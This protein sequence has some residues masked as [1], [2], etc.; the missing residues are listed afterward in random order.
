MR[1]V[2]AHHRP[3]GP[4][5]DHYPWLAGP[6]GLG[7]GRRHDPLAGT[8]WLPTS[9]PTGRSTWSSLHLQAEIARRPRRRGDSLAAGHRRRSASAGSRMTSSP[10]PILSTRCRSP[11]GAARRFRNIRG[12]RQILNRHPDLGVD[13]VHRDFLSE[14]A[15]A[16]RLRP[17]RPRPV[18]RHPALRPQMADGAATRAAMASTK[19]MDQS[20]GMPLIVIPTGLPAGAA[21]C[22]PGG[23]PE[24]RGENLRFRHVITAGPWND[25]TVC[26]GDD[27]YVLHRPLSVPS[28]FPVDTVLRLCQSRQRSIHP[29]TSPRRA[30]R[31]VPRQRGAVVPAVGEGPSRHLVGRP[32]GRCT[33]T[34]AGRNA[35]TG[36]RG[37][38]RSA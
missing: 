8:I 13:F 18:L 35:A 7:P 1:I 9:W 15:V 22:A 24:R 2:H 34:E 4:R 3:L 32:K 38:E 27:R 23:L 19:M 20:H 33:T 12:I 28:N 21:A 25:P 14:D 30:R 29:P 6:D 31:P 17:A 5:P 36:I 37:F 11:A 16:A 26:A 10:T